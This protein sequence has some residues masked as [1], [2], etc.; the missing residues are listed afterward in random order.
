MGQLSIYSSSSA[1][2]HWP[3][4]KLPGIALGLWDQRGVGSGCCGNFGDFQVPR[5]GEAAWLPPPDLGVEEDLRVPKMLHLQ[6]PKSAD[7]PCGLFELVGK[8]SGKSDYPHV[9]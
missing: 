1:Q 4:P 2:S 3:R 8:Q 9:L 7:W 6:N 5:C